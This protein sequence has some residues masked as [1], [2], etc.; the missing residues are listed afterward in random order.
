MRKYR[1]GYPGGKRVSCCGDLHSAIP[2][3]VLCRAAAGRGDLPI[4]AVEV[5]DDRPV[6][7]VL[8]REELD[9]LHATEGQKV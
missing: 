5:V 4:V 6:V 7:C 3:A 9:I 1:A 2:D 8:T